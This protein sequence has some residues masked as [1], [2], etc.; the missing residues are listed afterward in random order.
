MDM[1]LGLE[2]KF[3][4]FDDELTVTDGTRIEGYASLFGA[5]DQGGDVVE[6]GAY[7]ASLKR[8]GAEA[9]SRFTGHVNSITVEVK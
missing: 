5:R 2:R 8:I 3:C 1:E 6:P 7:A 9:K 4:R